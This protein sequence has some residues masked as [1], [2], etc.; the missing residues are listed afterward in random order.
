MKK[1]NLYKFKVFLL[2]VLVISS[3]SVFSQSNMSYKATLFAINPT[4]DPNKPFYK[5]NLF[6]TTG[7][8]TIHPG[9]QIS[10][11]VFGCNSVSAKIN[12]S[13]VKDQVGFHSGYTQILI[14]LFVVN[15]RKKYLKFAFGPVVHYRKD[16]SNILGYTDEGYYYDFNFS[17]YKMTWLSF[18]LEYGIYKTSD[19][20]FVLTLSQVYPR[21]I[22]LFFGYKYWFTRKKV[23]C[24]GCSAF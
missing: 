6:D 12:Q 2:F 23:G 11:E 16:W 7:F 18:E 5:D 22:G 4:N 8:F 10:A 13:Y 21:S 9:F 20:D 3:V 19:W 14:S 15:Q 24:G 1:Y 17:Q